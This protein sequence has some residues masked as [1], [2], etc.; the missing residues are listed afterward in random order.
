M[1]SMVSAPSLDFCYYS[2][3]VLA[4]AVTLSF[5][6]ATPSVQQVVRRCHRQLL[7]SDQGRSYE[8]NSLNGHYLFRWTTYLHFNCGYPTDPQASSMI[9]FVPPPHFDR[10]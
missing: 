9:M 2:E 4:S 6:L 8:T 7:P 3:S 5:R 10:E 1:T